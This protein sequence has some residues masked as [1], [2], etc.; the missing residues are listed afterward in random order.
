MSKQKSE[1]LSHR[2]IQLAELDIL[3]A[4]IKVL[5]KHH[6][7]YWAYGG[8]AIGAVRHQGFIPWDDDIDLVMSRPD[9]EK[10][11][12]IAQTEGLGD[13]NYE[14][15]C[16]EAGNGD[17][18]IPK[19]IN[20]QVVLESVSKTEDFLWLDIFPLDG[21]PDENPEKY[22]KKVKHYRDNTYLRTLRY[23]RG[24]EQK[25]PLKSLAATP[26]K[27]RN[28]NDVLAKLMRMSRKYDF[29]SAQK[30]VGPVFWASHPGDILQ[31]SWLNK[32]IQLPFED[33]KINVFA[34]Y[35]AYLTGRFGANYMELPPESARV[36]HEI[37]ARRAKH[38]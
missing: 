27:L 4:L 33:I 7:K 22:Y 5:N 28:I 18:A 26:Y 2:E 12:K 31:K 16:F 37:K 6:L 38:D 24:V 20:R 30:H 13:P 25:N 3:K 34:D 19:I 32:T 10:L 35:D 9:F 8:T 21:Y 29:D 36:T 17:N 1:Y 14:L 15:Y 11:A 23:K